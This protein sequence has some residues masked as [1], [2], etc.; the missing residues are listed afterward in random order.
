MDMTEIATR[1]LDAW[2]ETDAVARDK[3]LAEVFA[4]DVR[5][6]DPL[7]DVTG[8]SALGHLVGSVQERFPGM[9]FRLH[10]NVE[11]H[12]DIARFL[13]ALGPAGGDPLVIGFDVITVN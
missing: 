8:L 11:A 13:W 6:V 9:A 3:A 10:G 4:D 5:F 12:H 7:A 1:Y 2:N